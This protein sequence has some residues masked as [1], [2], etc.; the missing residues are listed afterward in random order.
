MTYQKL[1]AQNWGYQLQA[2]I[3]QLAKAPYDLIVMDFSRDGTDEAAFTKA[4]I[5]SLRTNHPNRKMLAYISIGEASD[6]RSFWQDN[7]TKYA[8][9]D[10]RA[11]GDLTK[12]APSWL[13]PSNLDW[14]N[15]RKVRF[16]EPAWKQ[17]VYDWI[18]KILLTGFDGI[19]MDIVDAYYY[20]GREI[21]RRLLKP[22]DPKTIEDSA[23]RM[24]ELVL[25]ISEYCRK[26]YVNFSVVP[27]NAAY[28]LDDLGE[29]KEVL[30]Q[31]YLE[32]ISAIACESI[33]CPGGE[34]MN[35]P[36]TPD[37]DLINTLRDQYLAAGVPVYSVDYLNNA[38]IRNK[39][40]RAAIKAG[41]VPYAAAS[42][43]LDAM[44]LGD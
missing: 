15:S 9:E 8:H 18:E 36:Y 4:Q 5:N 33:F 10:K 30:K 25:T 39:Y 1:K 17:I 34:D 29:G 38:R 31:R 27:Q 41:F 23:A 43:E 44:Y 22:G 11:L 2:S 14:P 37:I 6:Y 16:W 40:Y 19:Y 13:G 3:P 35:N 28:I 21:N 7:W 26:A 24:V 12:N 20:W 42:R 32:A